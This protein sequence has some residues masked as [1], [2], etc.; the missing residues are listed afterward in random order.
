MVDSFR[1]LGLRCQLLRTSFALL[2]AVSAMREWSEAYD[3]VTAR[4][5]EHVR[6]E[7]W[8]NRHAIAPHGTVHGNHLE[9]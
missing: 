5:A 6:A 8:A 9:P 1:R 2:R 3:V 4:S 7:S